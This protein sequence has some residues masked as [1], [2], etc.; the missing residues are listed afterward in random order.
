MFEDQASPGEREGFTLIELLVVIV[1]LGILVAIAVPS[2]LS[3]R[4]SAQRPPRSRTSARRSRPPRATTRTTTRPTPASPAPSLR[5]QAPGVCPN[6][7]AGAERGRRGYCVQDTEGRSVR[8]HRRYTGGNGGTS[9][10]RL[11]RLRRRATRPRNPQHRATAVR[12][13]GAGDRALGR[14]SGRAITRR[15]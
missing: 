14:V 9:T 15:G 12:R 13:E 10:D 6:V 7:K 5:T 8:L 2:Y 4:S 1:I 11:R 3:F